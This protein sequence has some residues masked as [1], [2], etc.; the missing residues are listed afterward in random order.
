MFNIAI[1]PLFFS[2]AMVALFTYFLVVLVYLATPIGDVKISIL[3]R[4]FADKNISRY[5]IWYHLA[6]FIWTYYTIL[7]V[8]YC[9]VAGAVGEWYWA[10]DKSQIM[11]LTVLNAFTRTMVYHLGS[12]IL[13]SLLITIV[14]LI[15][16]LLYQLQKQVS[17]SANPYLKYIVACAQCCMKM[18]QVLMKFINKNAYIYIAITGK[19]FFSAA[20][21]A[22]ALLL[23]NAAKTIAVTYVTNIVLFFTKLAVVGMNA[24]LGWFI[25]LSF[26]NLF[27]DI[28]FPNLTVGLL[29]L[30]T[31]LIISVFFGNYEITI[32]T[33]FL[34]VLEDLDKNDGSVER[35]YMMTDTMRHIMAKK[36]DLKLTRTKRTL[37]QKYLQN[38]DFR[39]PVI[40]AT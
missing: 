1:M 30:E 21:S 26:P 23:K 31:F 12:I 7:G 29:G 40:V 19:S 28:T 16:I 37:P 9:T 15:R 11:K 14:E 32:D 17:K 22:T 34:S 4:S 3:G 33:I 10:R 18:V 6:G 8:A 39:F 24:L 13:G 20:S 25:L 5:M 35:P 38:K 27:P 2:I 36:V